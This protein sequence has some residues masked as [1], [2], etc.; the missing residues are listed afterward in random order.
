MLLGDLSCSPGTLRL[1]GSPG[2]SPIDSLPSIQ[3]GRTAL[4]G[5]ALLLAN[6][7]EASLGT[8]VV[9]PDVADP[10][11]RHSITDRLNGFSFTG[12]R[13]YGGTLTCSTPPCLI[14]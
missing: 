11:D 13:L 12:A 4:R 3:L 2:P 10:K 5:D 8:Q 14:P 7:L 6:M 9:K 1:I